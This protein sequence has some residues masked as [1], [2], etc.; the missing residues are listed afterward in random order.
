MAAIASQWWR[1]LVN[2]YEV[3]KG[4]VCLQFKNCVIHTERFR[5]ELLD[6]G[7]LYKSTCSN[8]RSCQANCTACNMLSQV[9]FNHCNVV[10]FYC[11]KTVSSDVVT[12][13]RFEDKD[14]NL[15]SEVKDKDLKSED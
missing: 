3:K 11:Q 14:K 13:L 10:N 4:S 5:G 1:R 2:A 9:G 15:W 12:N 7:V 6:N 8:R